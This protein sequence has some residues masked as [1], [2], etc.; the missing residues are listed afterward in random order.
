MVG[1]LQVCE[2]KVKGT[3][4]LMPALAVATISR[5]RRRDPQACALALALL[6]AGSASAQFSG[7]APTD[8]GSQLYFVTRVRLASELAQHLPATTAIYRI[9]AGA[10][11]RLTDPPPAGVGS[12]QQLQGNPQ[13][14]GD[15]RVFSYTEYL[16]CIGGSSCITRPS[17]SHSLLS[18]AG[19]PDGAPLAGEAQISRNGRFVFNALLF[20][21]FSFPPQANIR[22]LHDLETGTT[23]QVPVRPA[24]GQQAVTSDG[25]VLGFDPQS[26]ALIL[27]SPQ[28]ARSLSTSEQPATA[29]VDDAATWVV[30]ETAS[31]PSDGVHLRALELGSGRDVL[32]ARS[33][34]ALNASIANDGNL[35]AYV[36]VPGVAQVAQV[37]TIHPDGTGNTQLTSFP[38]AVD[39]AV[40][41]GLGGVVFAVTGSRLVQIDT[42]SGA[43]QELIGRTPV[44]VPG[45]LAL[46]PGSILPIRGSGLTD[47][48]AVA[49]V[50]LPSELDGVRVL[51]DGVPLP[52]LTISPW[53][54]WFQV[55]FELAPRAA[56][57]VALEHSSVFEGCPA[58]Q[59]AVVPRFPY[60]FDSGSL[61]A[62]H[63]DFS[64]LV[65]VGSPAQ[66]GE[67]IHAYAVG[68]GAVAP[69]MTTGIPAPLDRLFPLADPFECHVGYDQDGQPLEVTFAGLAPGLIGI[70]QVDIRMPGAAPDTGWLFV[71][72]GTPG[73]ATERHGG[74]LPVGPAQL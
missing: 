31:T 41:A 20:P 68:L 26:G 71:N 60:F 33:G 58:T 27:W 19:Q 36:A 47:S 53:E 25:R 54:V 70:Y 11:E 37:F 9:R 48:T 55:P 18:V 49:P 62:G 34:S 50:P 22:E 17:T 63:Q 51:A 61:I 8:D 64:G 66:P 4:Y 73:S 42:H 15:G 67:I 40:I 46:M 12:P 43:V 69:A 14:S 57:T 23:V 35:V 65:G 59:V 44:C 13:V 29:I 3:Y 2:Q 74:L 1:N 6:F 45:F 16:Q 56:I 5:A 72:C 24:S 28:G 7:L 10:I 21:G 32:L 52:L 30:Y 39:T 38:Q